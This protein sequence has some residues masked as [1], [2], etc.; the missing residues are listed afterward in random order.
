[1]ATVAQ[2]EIRKGATG[3]LSKI[4]TQKRRRV[5]DWTHL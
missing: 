2:P 3:V 5:N 1:M 4:I